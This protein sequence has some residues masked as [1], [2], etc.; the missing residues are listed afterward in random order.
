MAGRPPRAL[1]VFAASAAFLHGRAA[2]TQALPPSAPGVRAALEVTVLDL[3]VVATK[4]GRFVKDLMKGDFTVKV[5]GKQAPIDYFTKVEAGQ[6]VGPDLAGASPDLILDTYRASTGDRY[7]ARQFVLFFDDEHMLP[8][9]LPRAVEGARDLVTRLAPS[10]QAAV[11]CYNRGTTRVLTPF[12]S[13]K[14]ALLDGLI[15][16][17]KLPPNGLRWEQD[18]EQSRRDALSARTQGGRASAVRNWAQQAFSREKAM[19]EDVRRALSALAA[20]SGKR[21]FLYV[22]SGFEMRPGQSFAQ[23]LYAGALSGRL[24][25][26]FDYTVA[27]DFGKTVREANAAGITI[28]AVDARGLVPDIDAADSA[29]IPV[30]RFFTDANRREGM[31]GF[32]GETGGQIYENRNTFK[33]AV[34]QVVREASSFYSIGVTLSS[35]P[36]KDEH[37]IEVTTSRPGVALRTRRT[38]VAKPPAQA[39][40]DRTEMA[41]VTPDVQGDFPVEL[42][43]GPAKPAGSGRRVSPFEVRIPVTA[44]TFRADGERRVAEIDFSFAAAEDNGDRSTPVVQRKRISIDAAAWDP[45]KTPFAILTGEAKSRTGNQR[46][47]ATVR[48]VATNR[49]GIG[50]ASVRIE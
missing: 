4:D 22:S 23:A 34:D 25:Q 32:A 9:D 8:E 6:L 29:V 14:E 39:V 10:D 27:P 44:L 15:R 1:L 2:R 49:I 20:R 40:L 28:Y 24:L 18:F 37:R 45:G 41:L 43:I 48:D 16:L 7:L 31:A 21:I 11:F 12:T 13:S 35:L 46:F 19:L 17:A 50:S 47:V 38:F 33:G 30:N 36:T 3:D 26:Q 5:D 42:L